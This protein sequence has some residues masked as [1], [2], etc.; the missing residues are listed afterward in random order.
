MSP[1]GLA[2]ANLAHQRA[3]T[4]ISVVGVAFTVVLMFMQLGF[5]GAVNRTST[6]LYDLLEFD[7]LLVSS[8]YLNLARSSNFPRSRLTQARS[9][10]GVK[11]V[12]PLSA[13]IGTWRDPRPR[14]VRP[15]WTILVLAVEPASLGRL[16][17]GGGPTVFG[18]PQERAERQTALS[19]LDAVVLDRSSWPEYGDPQTRRPGAVNELNGRRVE[20]VG[21]I[22]MGTGFAFNG[23][24]MT[25]EETFVRVGAGTPDRT[26][27]GLVKLA[28]G[29]SPAAVAAQL[30][31]LL[32]PDVHVLSRAQINARERE[33]WRTKTAAGQFFSVGVALAVVV[34]VVFVYQMLAGDISKHL[35][36][37]ATVKAL[38]YRRGYLGRVVLYQGVLLALV[39][40]L[41]GLLTALAGYALTRGQARVPIGMTGLR[42]LLVLALTVAMCGAAALLAVRKVHSADPADLF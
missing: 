34:G 35:P 17:R 36:E 15:S 24:V 12:L 26:T 6:L 29:A 33:Y 5:L 27:F 28:P 22:E 37:Y 30:K 31:R 16:F 18:S 39:G 2:R 7:L 41:P 8:E 42:A 19:R 10:A 14:Q 32:P 40:Y 9:A 13:G 23:L 38:G 25:S 21:D 3:R 20:V 4:I 1:F 11:D